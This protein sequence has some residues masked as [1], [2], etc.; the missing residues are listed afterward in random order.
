MAI[1]LQDVC[2]G[3]GTVMGG[4]IRTA[5]AGKYGLKTFGGIH[6]HF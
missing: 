2:P 4:S 3:S 1:Y 6:G 5:K